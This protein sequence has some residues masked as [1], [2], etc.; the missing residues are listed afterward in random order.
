MRSTWARFAKDPESG[1]G[2]NAIGTGSEFLDGAADLDV[3]VFSGDPAGVR[4]ARQSELDGRCAF[5]RGLLTTGK[6]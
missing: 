4:V 6:T 1:P 5:W 3:A 2:W